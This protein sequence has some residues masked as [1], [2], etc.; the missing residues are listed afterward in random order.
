M[1]LSP[2]CLQPWYGEFPYSTFND[3]SSGVLGL[4]IPTT[5]RTVSSIIKTDFQALKSLVLS[6]SKPQPV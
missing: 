6:K 4:P 2:P 5:T 3:I 1:F